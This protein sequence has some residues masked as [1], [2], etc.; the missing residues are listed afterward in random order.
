MLRSSI[1]TQLI[2]PSAPRLE[3]NAFP[4]RSILVVLCRTAL[5]GPGL[6]IAKYIT[7]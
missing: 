4:A 5:D 1:Q 6:I 3:D 2:L 7:V